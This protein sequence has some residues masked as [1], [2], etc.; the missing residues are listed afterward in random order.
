MSSESN[1]PS[2]PPPPSKLPPPTGNFITDVYQVRFSSFF[3]ESRAHTNKECHACYRHSVCAEQLAWWDSEWGW[4]R[5]RARD[6]DKQGAF[7]AGNWAMATFVV[8]SLGSFHLCQ[9]QMSD[10][11]RKVTRIIEGMPRRAVKQESSEEPTSTS[12]SK[13]SDS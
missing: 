7:V 3:P 11:R 9:K 12:S 8:I 6:F 2:I 5:R 10:E 4:D 13:G 1:A